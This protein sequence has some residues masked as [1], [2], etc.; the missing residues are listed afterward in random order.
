MGGREV[1][2]TVDGVPGGSAAA[3]AQRNRAKA[4]R[5]LAQADHWERGAAGEREVGAVLCGLAD[6]YVTL[7]DLSVPGSRANIDHVVV[8]STGVYVIDAKNYAGAL[9]A[10]KGTLWRGRFPIR[11]ECDGVAWQ[12]STLA[13]LLGR[14]VA[15][16]LCFVGTTLPQAV[17]Q[18]GAVTV[19]TVAALGDVVST[20]TGSPDD[21]ARADA[22]RILAPLVRASGGQAM[23]HANTPAG[24]RRPDGFQQIQPTSTPPW[25]GA[26][27]PTQ[28]RPKP[29]RRDN[30]RKGRLP[31][32]LALAVA[33]VVAIPAGAGLLA[34][35]FARSIPTPSTAAPA[36]LSSMQ[37]AVPA[38]PATTSAASTL[39]GDAAVPSAPPTI[40]FSCASPGA[41]W[42]AT[43]AA[44]KF[45]GD[46]DGFSMCY[47]S[48]TGDWI[49]W[50]TFRSGV[51]TPYSIGPNT[52]GEILQIKSSR[53]GMLAV[54]DATVSNFVAPTE[55]C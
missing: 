45:R 19:C 14:E 9:T 21:S 47:Q 53:K 54:D 33:A 39:P 32:V 40:V 51:T 10:G 1:T 15:P 22:I 7:H 30:A 43:L 17:Q 2:S 11:K 41:G 13:T 49:Y 24:F 8:S 34:R 28:M 31:M 25:L 42:T 37:R 38:A 35:A 6:E 52:A 36:V 26:A 44:T 48:P 3:R 18:L 4:D 5:L 16:V 12:A 50:G 46:P 29:S 27:G 55:P 20:S 23:R